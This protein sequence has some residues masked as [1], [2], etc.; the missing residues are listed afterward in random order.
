MDQYSKNNYIVPIYIDTNA[1]LDVLASIE[2]GFS[3]VEKLTTQTTQSSNKGVDSNTS[4]GTEF[5]IP[6]IL[7]L[8]KVNLGLSTRGCLQTKAKGEWRRK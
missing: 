6:N 3:V 5:G 8:L 7:N 4:G 2:G 1:L